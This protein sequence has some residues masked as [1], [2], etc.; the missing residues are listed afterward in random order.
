MPVI[1]HTTNFNSTS[2]YAGHYNIVGG[3]LSITVTTGSENLTPGTDWQ[4]FQSSSIGSFTFTPDTGVS[5]ISRNNNK[6]LSQLGST[7]ILKYISGQ[8]FH[9]VGD[10]TI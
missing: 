2:S 8:T 5:V 9:L 6:R 7:G 10:L 1:T 3:D 4:F